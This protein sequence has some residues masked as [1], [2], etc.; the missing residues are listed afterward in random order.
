ME[1]NIC[2]I[3][4]NSPSFLICDIC[5]KNKHYCAT[6]YKNS[7]NTEA[8]RQHSVH[9]VADSSKKFTSFDEVLLALLP[10]ES[11][12]KHSKRTIEYV[13][14]KCGLAIC[15]DCL[16]VGEHKGHD[17]VTFDDGW[18]ELIKKA[19]QVES[20]IQEKYK[21]VKK[22]LEE[23]TELKNKL[24]TKYDSYEKQ[25]VIEMSKIL[26][27]VRTKEEQL[28]SKIKEEKESETKK[29]DECYLTLS[30]INSILEK[31][32]GISTIIQ[33]KKSPSLYNDIKSAEDFKMPESLSVYKDKDFRIEEVFNSTQIVTS[34]EKIELHLGASPIKF[35]TNNSDFMISNN[36]STV[37]RI[38]EGTHDLPIYSITPFFG[39]VHEFKIKID[40]L[41]N[42]VGL[43]V[44]SNNYDSA[45]YNQAFLFSNGTGY[46]GLL[47]RFYKGETII[48]TLD[49]NQLI[50]KISGPSVNTQVSIT[51]QP[52]YIAAEIYSSGE[53]ISSII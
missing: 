28:K 27:A 11:C 45:C 36:G 38:H 33:E 43:G 10:D 34:I 14:K 20:K 15:S 16:L 52:Y 24:D 1:S 41:T 12:M 50:F 3:C 17:A 32:K 5:T 29:I 37:K 18:N 48:L 49:F 22:M 30:R 26:D 9:F 23:I 40:E 44:H 8:R 51:N 19:S 7:H 35:I 53:Q 25:I 13:C 4:E 31:R 42:I 47:G 6:C 21:E 39:G 2:D 46:G